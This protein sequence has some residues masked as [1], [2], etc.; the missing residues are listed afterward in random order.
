MNTTA[1]SAKD[2]AAAQSASNEVF[3]P[4]GAAYEAWKDDVNQYAALRTE[5]QGQAPPYVKITNKAM[6][7]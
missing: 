7:A 5:F 1:F 2:Q 6:K 3:F 4:R